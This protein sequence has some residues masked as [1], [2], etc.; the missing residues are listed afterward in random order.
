MNFAYNWENEITDIICV[1]LLWIES[2]LLFLSHR[3]GINSWYIPP[4]TRKNYQIVICSFILWNFFQE[5][6]TN[7][8]FVSEFWGAFLHERSVKFSLFMNDS[9]CKILPNF[10]IV[11]KLFDFLLHFSDLR[12]PRSEIA[13][14]ELPLQNLLS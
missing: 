7:E 14:V 2:M 5:M 8:E 4:L 10:E 3:T 6:F 13:S 12:I 1:E 9:L 11:T